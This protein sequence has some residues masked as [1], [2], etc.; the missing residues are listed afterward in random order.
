MKYNFK[1]AAALVACGLMAVSITAC[2]KKNEENK[3][4]A[5]TE[6]VTEAVSEEVSQEADAQLSKEEYVSKVNELTSIS[7]NV[8]SQVLTLSDKI[9]KQEL[10]QTAA[11]A[12]LDKIKAVAKGYT[13]FAEGVNPP[14]EYKD[15]HSKLAEEA[16][17]L[18]AS[19]NS[20]LDTLGKKFNNETISEEEVSKI[21]TEYGTNLDA[22][23]NTAKEVVGENK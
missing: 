1:K 14:E 7:G 6:A 5:T 22:L 8:L 16:K 23:N 20:F 15:V 19:T 4:E 17:N 2:G 18:E 9:N 12:E 11:F 13:E 21:Q 10:D 3:A